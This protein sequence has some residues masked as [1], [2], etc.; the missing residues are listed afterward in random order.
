MVGEIDQRGGGVR[1]GR[2]TA[3]LSGPNWLARS[4]AMLFGS[5]VVG[6]I[7]GDVVGFQLVGLGEVVGSEVVGDIAGDVVGVRGGRR[8]CRRCRWV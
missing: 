4:T 3:M 1:G 2:R 8:D 6:E 7:V 5:E